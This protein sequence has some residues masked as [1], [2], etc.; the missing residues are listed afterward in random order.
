MGDQATRFD[1]LEYEVRRLRRTTRVQAVGLVTALAA[2][3]LGATNEPGDLTLR[4]LKIV[5]E[6][7]KTRVLAGTLPADPARELGGVGFFLFDREGR[8]R[9]HVSTTRE[10]AAVVSVVG[11]DGKTGV[12]AMTSAPKAVITD[13]AVL[14]LTGNDGLTRVFLGMNADGAASL[15]LADRAVRVRIAAEAT[16]EGHA[17]FALFDRDGK[18]LR[19]SEESP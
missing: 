14:S 16:S 5:D 17:R 1:Q 7:G 3:V 11:I 12:H 6:D 8:R 15:R 19:W 10:N 9:I 13:A 18:T 4:T 2:V